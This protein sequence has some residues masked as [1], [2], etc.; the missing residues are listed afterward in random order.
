MEYN[1]LITRVQQASVDVPATDAILTG[2]HRTL[3][4]R[5]QQRQALLSLVMLLAVGTSVFF[6]Q[7]RNETRLTLA[8]CVSAHIDTPPTKTPA[9]LVGYRHSMYNRQIYTLL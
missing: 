4:H 9:P 1:E 6:M 5:R 8:E 2:M 7:P 3:R